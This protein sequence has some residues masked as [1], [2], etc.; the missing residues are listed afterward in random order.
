MKLK[1]LNELIKDEDKC[2]EYL[3]SAGI[4]KTFTNCI[5]CGSTS[6]G[7]IRGDRY[8]CYSCKKEWSRR[9]DSILSL[10]RFS[11]S[12]FLICLKYFSLEFS[13]EATSDEFELNYKTVKMLFNLF[14]MK[15]GDVDEAMLDK[16]AGIIKG[17]T[18]TIGL[19]YKDGKVR[20]VLDPST[21]PE[22]E[23]KAVRHRLQKSAAHYDFSYE[24]LKN[25]MM[26]TER[27][28]YISPLERFW[29][30]AAE[31]FYSYRGTEQKYFII[32]LK[33]L[34]FRFNHQNEDIFDAI[35]AKLA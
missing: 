12:E 35:V 16:F 33:E 2:E 18:E 21:P 5:G 22:V 3:R 28:G 32:F 6:L 30:F 25:E 31:R 29:R 1:E 9:K 13:A 7:M 14:R 23:I 24:R 34:E 15:I 26:N 17:D 11:Y 10:T 8:R 20:F 19:N 27:Q 4:L